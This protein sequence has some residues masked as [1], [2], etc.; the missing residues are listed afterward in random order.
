MNVQ[1]NEEPTISQSNSP[2]MLC[3]VPL[4]G[5]RS[6]HEISAT[7]QQ[8]ADNI[9]RTSSA[10]DTTNNK[11]KCTITSERLAQLKRIV[12]NAVKDRKIFTIKDK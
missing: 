9:F 3:V 5:K 11:Y 12:E 8:L 10:T 1:P 2:N 7:A 6:S 4:S